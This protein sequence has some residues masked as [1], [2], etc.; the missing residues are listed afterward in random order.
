M[1]PTITISEET[2]GKLQAL[3]RPFVDTPESVILDLATAELE[4]RGDSP[5]DPSDSEELMELNPDAPASLTHSRLLSATVDQQAIHRP[6]WNGV[7]DH[8]HVLARRRMGSF[9]AVFEASGANLHEGRYEENG[10]RYLPEAEFSIQGVDANVAWS[11]ALA[12]ARKLDVPIEVKLEWREKE[13]AAHP[14]RKAR[15]HWAPARNAVEV[16]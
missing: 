5:D 10:F 4:R 8:L 3:A 7:M 14:G 9:D 2:F 1:S 15:L 11:H 13:G 16:S 12:L 6:K